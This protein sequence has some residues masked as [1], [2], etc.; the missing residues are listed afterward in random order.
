MLAYSGQ[1]TVGSPHALGIDSSNMDLIKLSS[2]FNEDENDDILVRTKTVKISTT[3]KAKQFTNIH[4]WTAAFDIFMSI[5]HV[6]YPNLNLSL[7][8]Y[9]YNITAMSK[10]FGFHMARSY[11]EAFCRVRKVMRFDW[12]VVNDDL[13]RTVFY[14]HSN[15]RQTSNGNNNYRLNRQVGTSPFP[16]QAQQQNNPFPM[17][18][19]WAYC[20]SGECANMATCRLK[21]A[22]VRCSKKHAT[23][24]CR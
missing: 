21:H 18:Y 8:K 22:C 17:G 23:V 6:K 24:T 9:A 20:R 11:D 2:N 16:R 19:C 4:Q 7:I 13:W 10:Q 14:E 12:S 1:D 5:H 15:G 3:A